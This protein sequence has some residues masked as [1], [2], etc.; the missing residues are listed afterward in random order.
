M[1][2]EQS[3]GSAIV[4]AA[5]LLKGARRLLVITGAGLSAD[6][7]LPT[8]RGIGGLYESD[9]TEDGVPIEVALSGAMLALRPQL[10]W[11]YLSQVES[12]CRHAR[13]NEGHAAIVRME[14]HFRRLTVLTQNIDGFHRDAGTTHLIEMHGNV[15]E[16]YCTECARQWRVKDYAELG[17]RPRCEDCRGAV[18]PRVVL[19]GEMLP[20]AALLAL[21]GVIGEGIDAVLSI[22]TTSVF[23]YIAG[24]VR[25][26]VRI[27]VPTI[28]INPGES[29]VSSVVRL[30]IRERAA[31]VLPR[32]MRALES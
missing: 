2:A 15:H 30:R 29:E 23:P 17:I 20:K 5:G 9:A 21:Q 22:G 3:L 1:D 24:P 8:Y 16:L 14:R 25:Q 13:Y 27:G 4:E 31:V 19:F 10:T 18:R 11:K 32:L 6:S 26:A 7:G 28:E 12:A